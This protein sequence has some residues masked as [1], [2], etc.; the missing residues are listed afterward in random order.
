MGR[1]IAAA[2]VSGAEAAAVIDPPLGVDPRL[3][4]QRLA[5]REE[6]IDP[7]GGRLGSARRVV[8]CRTVALPDR[9]EPDDLSET[10]DGLE[11]GAAPGAKI[12]DQVSWGGRAVQADLAGCAFE[13]GHQG[14]FLSNSTAKYR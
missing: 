13:V 5:V 1:A 3:G 6:G 11:Q 10:A 4:E 14:R 7:T 9:L 2:T 8:I 12:A